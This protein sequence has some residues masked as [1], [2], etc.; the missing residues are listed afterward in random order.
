MTVTIT[1]PTGAKVRTA[2]STRFV[3]VYE[4]YVEG[5]SKGAEIEKGSSSLETLRTFL[6]RKG[7]LTT[8][9]STVDGQV[10]TGVRRIYELRPEVREVSA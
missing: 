5:A 8:Y 4:G 1:T 6:R 3:V 7:R 10:H 2:R 9:R